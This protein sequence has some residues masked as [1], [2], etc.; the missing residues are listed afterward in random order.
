[1]RRHRDRNLSSEIFQKFS[2]AISRRDRYVRLRNV[3]SENGAFK[4]SRE[5]QTNEQLEQK[6]RKVA[7][8]KYPRSGCGSPKLDFGDLP[9][10]TIA[11]PWKTRHREYQ[12]YQ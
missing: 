5:I 1:M 7:N 4:T 10:I 2:G 3:C 12:P 9:K 11:S 6:R 8:G